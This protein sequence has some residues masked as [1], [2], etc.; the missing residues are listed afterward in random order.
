[1][2]ATYAKVYM[3]IEIITSFNQRYYD[4]IGKECVNTWL[5]YWP[6][7]LDLTCYVEE[8]QL[9]NTKRIKQIDF[10]QL[11]LEYF[12][13]QQSSEKDRVKLFAKKAY[14][15]IHSMTN[16]QAD[17]II[18][19]DADNIFFKKIPLNFLETICSNDTL[20][21]FMGVWH[22]ENREDKTSKKFFSAE[23]GFFVLNP[24]HLGF[25]EFSNRY[26]EYYDCQIKDGLRRF[27]DGEVFGAV[28]KELEQKYQFNDLCGSFNKN[29]KSPMKHTVL[30]EYMHHY[31]SKHSKE[32][33]S[34]I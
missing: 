16:S 1:M 25:K 2:L 30:G 27:Y 22:N 33:F 9:E 34:N 32:N 3:K 31:K 20:A 14:S 11:P 18:W 10:D 21:T 17:R 6:D 24:Q 26:R 7:S 13:F 5:Q 19:I 4:L 15:I 28:V 8:F 23:T 29:Y 12:K